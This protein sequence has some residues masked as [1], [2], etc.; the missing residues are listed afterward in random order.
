[1][2]K[3]YGKH[4]K[5]STRSTTR[6]KQVSA[7]NKNDPICLSTNT[8]ENYDDQTAV[9]ENLKSKID[10][11]AHENLKSE[12]DKKSHEQLKL[13]VTHKNSKVQ[14]KLPKDKIKHMNPMK[15]CT[16]LMF[17]ASVKIIN[18]KEIFNE[19]E[20]LMKQNSI[21]DDNSLDQYILE[22]K[23]LSPQTSLSSGSIKSIRQ[24]L[25]LID[26]MEDDKNND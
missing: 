5:V 9:H 16:M 7:K 17:G 6:I 15:L 25:E 21:Q 13:D 19:L 11:M 20:P 4:D 18:S 14:S 23:I 10:P 3:T 8:K 26:L 24:N 12:I 22:I 2:A 1:M